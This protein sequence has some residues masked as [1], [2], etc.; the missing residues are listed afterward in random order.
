MVNLYS[1]EVPCLTSS[2]FRDSIFERTISWLI[3]AVYLM[4]I[5]LANS[6]FASCHCLADFK[7]GHQ[8]PSTK[9]FEGVSVSEPIRYE[10][11]SI[12]CFDNVGQ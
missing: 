2:S 10:E 7:A 8:L 9:V 11:I 1:F 4:L 12:L 3:V 6:G 5:V